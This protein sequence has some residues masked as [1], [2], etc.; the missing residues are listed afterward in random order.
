MS[1]GENIKN[2]RLLND[3]TQEQL[4]NK[5]GVTISMISQIERGTK[6]VTLPLGKQLAEVF[7]CT[8]DDLFNDVRSVSNGK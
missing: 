5:V 3:M 7:G 6:A 2:L 1:I 8:I 4:G